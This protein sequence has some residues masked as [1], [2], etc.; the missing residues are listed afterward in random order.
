MRSKTTLAD[1]QRIVLEDYVMSELDGLIDF[2]TGEI[3]ESRSYDRQDYH[4]KQGTLRPTFTDCTSPEA[5]SRFMEHVDRRTLI[6][7]NNCRRLFDLDKGNHHLYGKQV[8]F[9]N[10]QYQR[11]NQLI[12][13]LDYANAIIST[14]AKLAQSLGVRRD[15]LHRYLSTLGPLIR[16]EGYREGMAYGA[17]KVLVSPAYGYR[18]NKSDLEQAQS[19]SLASW[20]RAQN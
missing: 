17:I 20:Y 10:Q 5:L 6:T 12:K 15:H 16:V 3:L 13:R 18:Y 9:S 2:R 14:P 1:A 7:R 4:A 19:A 8:T 11:M